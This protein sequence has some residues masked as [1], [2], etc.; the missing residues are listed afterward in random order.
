MQA[1][2]TSPLPLSVK[3][4]A[5]AL[6]C[7]PLMASAQ[8]YTAKVLPT[9]AGALGCTTQGL[10]LNDAGDVLGG[11]YFKNTNVFAWLLAAAIQSGVSSVGKSVVWRA[12]GTVQ[13]LS[14]GYAYGFNAAGNV[15]GYNQ[16]TG[17]NAIWKGTL[18]STWTPPSGLGGKWHMVDSAREHALSRGGKA[19]LIA[20]DDGRSYTVN[21]TPL[22]LG[23]VVGNT[24]RKLSAP[25]TECR[26]SNTDTRKYYAINDA[27]QVGLLAS[28]LEFTDELDA[29]GSNIPADHVQPCLWTGTAWTVGPAVPPAKRVPGVTILAQDAQLDG[30]DDSGGMLIH[31]GD[32]KAFYWSGADSALVPVP[33]QVRA[34][35]AN[36]ER[37]GGSALSNNNPMDR[38]TVWRNGVAVDLNTLTTL[39]SGVVL[40]TA[41]ASNKKGQILATSIPFDGD[42]TKAKLVLLTPR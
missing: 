8:T 9:P 25:P 6:I 20:L 16:L 2:R 3:A 23:T 32:D 21:N 27:G 28:W 40:H 29:Y 41:Q 24:S 35:G 42:S 31:A 38:A 13:T 5:L 34:L 17:G 37:L 4:A 39:P 18:K 11:C 36:G 30:M 19:I 1:Q 22:T 7:L 14:G 15:L 33:I 26:M 10:S 12:N